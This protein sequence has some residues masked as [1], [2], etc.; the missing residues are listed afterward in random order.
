M[1]STRNSIAVYGASGH[2]G[3]FVIREAHRRGLPVVAVG[4]SA[5]RLGATVPAGVPQHVARLEDSHALTQAFL[6]CATVINCAGPFLDTAAPVAM[7]ALR[8]G[9][10][11]IDVTA[12][13]S[14]AQATF[15]NLDTPARAAGRVVVPAAGFYGGLADLL[16]TSLATAGN[17][18]TITVAIALDRWWPTPG[19][20]KTGERNSAPRVVWTHGELTTFTP[21][22]SIEEWS[23]AKPLNRQSMVELPFSEVITLSHHLSVGTI[24]SL[25]NRHALADIR[26]VATPPPTAVD[27]HG[28]S[29][30]RFEMQVQLLQSGVTTFA[31]VRGQDIYAVTAPIVI[32]AA[33]QLQARSAQRCGALALAEATQPAQM[34]RALDGSALELFG[35]QPRR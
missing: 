35:Q 6:G 11:C 13:Q 3:Q 24:R 31:G 29:A 34:L 21:S 23:F 25:I 12:E 20:R 4:R 32:E 10:H 16:A 14:S 1:G 18:E 30:Q 17:I 28:R 33:L 7:A 26:D 9:C 19:T 27:D 8:A 22:A 5:A 2:T 15:A